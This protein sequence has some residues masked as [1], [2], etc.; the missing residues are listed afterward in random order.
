MLTVLDL[1]SQINNSSNQRTPE[2]SAITSRQQYLP[3]KYNLDENNDDD[4]VKS[5]FSEFEDYIDDQFD[6]A[7]SSDSDS[8]TDTD[9]A[10]QLAYWV[11]TF[12]ISNSSLSVLLALLRQK[13]PVITACLNSLLNRYLWLKWYHW[14]CVIISHYGVNL[15]YMF[16]KFTLRMIEFLLTL[17]NVT[18]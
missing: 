16:L 14:Y 11:A 6:S 2:L 5:N 3:T 9:L 13:H 10:T 1:Q 17:N 8:E 18:L 4:V 15:C 7:I 12:N